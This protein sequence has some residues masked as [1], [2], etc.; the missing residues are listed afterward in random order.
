MKTFLP[1]EKVLEFLDK[2]LHES[3]EVGFTKTR[4]SRDILVE[5]I[6]KRK[7]TTYLKPLILVLEMVLNM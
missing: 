5:E 7:I 4:I 2:I 6:Q 3:S 1:R